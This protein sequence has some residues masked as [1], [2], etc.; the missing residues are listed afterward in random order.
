LAATL[1]TAWRII[2]GNPFGGLPP[3]RPYPALVRPGLAWIKVGRYW[4]AYRTTP[5]LRIDAVFYE[6]ADIPGRL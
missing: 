1:E 5:R 3:P 4:V 2:G 6:T